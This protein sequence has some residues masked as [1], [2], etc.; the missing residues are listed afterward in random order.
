M[1]Y[2][3]NNI[4]YYIK[5]TCSKHSNLKRLSN[6]IFKKQD[7]IIC[8]LQEFHFKEVDEKQKD[9]KDIPGKH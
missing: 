9:G 2:L 7:P 4:D 3:F 8:W 6:Y 1:I 5:L